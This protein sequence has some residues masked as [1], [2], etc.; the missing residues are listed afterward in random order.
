MNL[1]ANIIASFFL[2]LGASF[3]SNLFLIRL[4]AK[5]NIIDRP[6]GRSNHVHATPRGGGIGILF[7]LI[8]GFVYLSQTNEHSLDFMLI[9]MMVFL[10]VLSFCDDIKSLSPLVRLLAQVVVCWIGI[11]FFFSNNLFFGGF[12]PKALDHALVTFFWVG[13]INIFNFMDGINGISF[14]ESLTIFLGIFLLSVLK[15]DQELYDNVCL[16]GIA[17]I[18]GFAILNLRGKIFLGDVGSIILGFLLGFLLLNL[19]IKESPFYALVLPLYYFADAG[20][21]LLK[22]II[23]KERIWEAHSKHLYQ[24]AYRGCKSQNKVLWV[25]AAGN[26]GYILLCLMMEKEFILFIGGS[27]LLMQFLI[28]ERY[29]KN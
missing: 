10:A 17:A 27:I 1:G 11:S 19:W 15:T 29:A 4:L 21:T 3:F 23:K 13:F 6:N 24:R 8:L 18:S 26:A 28:L 2:V 7:S 16:L 5:K 9:L 14:L 22:R 20:T 25:V 12:F